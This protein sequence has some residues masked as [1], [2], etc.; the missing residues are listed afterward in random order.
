M[1]GQVREGYAARKKHEVTSTL[2]ARQ[3]IR[4]LNARNKRIKLQR[5]WNLLMDKSGERKSEDSFLKDWAKRSCMNRGR[6]DRQLRLKGL[7]AGSATLRN[8]LRGRLCA[9]KQAKEKVSDWKKEQW[10]KWRRQLA[11]KICKAREI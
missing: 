1:G 2:K 3:S 4:V 11:E 10:Q 6:W 8:K 5:A 9:L 7:I